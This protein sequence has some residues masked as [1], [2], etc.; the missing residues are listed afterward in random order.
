M[1]KQSKKRQQSY[2]VSAA[3]RAQQDPRPKCVTC[4][5][6]DEV[7]Q[8]LKG[9]FLKP[10]RVLRQEEL[11]KMDWRELQKLAAVRLI[12]LLIK[13]AERPTR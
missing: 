4:A 13:V 5:A 11:K 10:R 9:A 3:S 6:A 12:F 1:P 7:R 2:T 8:Q